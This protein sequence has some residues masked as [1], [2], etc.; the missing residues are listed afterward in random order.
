MGSKVIQLLGR[1]MRRSFNGYAVSVVSR[2]KLSC[3]LW[4][5]LQVDAEEPPGEKPWAMRCRQRWREV[6]FVDT[7]DEEE[8]RER[9][10]TKKKRREPKKTEKLIQA[11]GV[12][13][14]GRSRCPAAPHRPSPRSDS[15]RGR[16][17]LTRDVWQNPLLSP[18]GTRLG[19]YSSLDTVEYRT[20]SLDWLMD[21]LLLRVTKDE[22][23]LLV[24]RPGVT[25]FLRRGDT[26]YT[27]PHAIGL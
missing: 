15:H 7:P 4:L 13:R 22:T 12:Q 1:Q 16:S 9:E 23:D 18:K 2:I 8:E 10:A 19:L 3:S 27:T 11:S 14:R 21:W 24:W 25:Q 20:G 5:I 6:M 17:D 26:E